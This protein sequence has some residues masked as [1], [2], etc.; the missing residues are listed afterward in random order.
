MTLYSQN[1]SSV[2]KTPLVEHYF[3]GGPRLT[4]DASVK[5]D[6]N[7]QSILELTMAERIHVPNPNFIGAQGLVWLSLVFFF[8]HVLD[9]VQLV[10]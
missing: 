10:T 1:H 4:W 3:E 9:D 5:K 2:P 6:I 7:F 8:F